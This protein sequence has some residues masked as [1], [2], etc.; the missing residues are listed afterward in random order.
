MDY[1]G[2]SRL[3]RYE[4]ADA[5]VME[6]IGR[7][8]GVSAVL[9]EVL[10]ARGVATGEEAV[11]FL[12]RP[13]D[14][15]A[16]ASL[17]PDADAL[18]ER[19]ASALEHGERIA[20]H[21]HDDADGVTATVVMLEALAMLGA[22]PSAYIPDRRTEG[23]GLNERE[24]ERLSSSG[25]S[26]LLTVDSCV[27]ERALI[28]RAR[29][30]GIDTIVTDH[31][32]IPAELPP[33][34]A[35]VNPKR[36]E[37]SFPYPL[38]AGVGVSLRVADLLASRLSGR[39][40]APAPA[41]VVDRGAWRDEAFA[42]AAVGS[43]ADKVPLTGENRIIVSEGLRTL[44]AT[45]RPGLRALL[46]SGRLWGAPLSVSD[47]R[48]AVA[49]IFG[50]VSD[51]RGGNRALDLLLSPDVATARAIVESLAGERARWL[52]TARGAWSRAEKSVEDGE[53]AGSPVRVLD[54]EIPVG[55]AGYTAG[56][57]VD[58]TGDPVVVVVRRNGEAVAEARGPAGFNFVTAFDTMADLF[59]GYGGHPRAAGFSI[60]SRDIPR[61]VERM[62][63]YAAANPPTLVPQTI[64]AEVPFD[65]ATP[66][67]AAELERLAP[68]GEGN[69]PAVLLCRGVRAAD[70]AA[71]R[72]SGLRFRTPVRLSDEPA[73]IVY[74]LRHD[75]GI[76]FASVIDRVAEARGE[77]R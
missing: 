68:F 9:A 14:G 20:V 2:S 32:E 40:A 46:E 56:R 15:L 41:L 47:V 53:A 65:A 42:L 75:D 51:G 24:L 22:A 59:L 5:G 66:E 1:R 64:E 12:E 39:F 34:V 62:S 4:P 3:W 76:A 74:R 23:H 38:M 30:L 55:V 7:A 25:V 19:I 61:F 72:A 37:S 45:D 57:A 17:L 52:D 28:G 26:L 58:E 67:L 11:L 10:A 50:R 54:L 43:I 69:R 21:G 27:S 49:P 29:G 8:T 44:P 35:V 6:V 73:A 77:G 71:A 13:R 48:E 33:A 63:D 18:V 70:L 60:R 36:R 16:D 31:H